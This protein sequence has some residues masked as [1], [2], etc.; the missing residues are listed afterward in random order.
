MIF[1]AGMILGAF[2]GGFSAR[3]R[4]GS[5]FDIAQYA[6]VGGL[7]GLVLGLALTVAVDRIL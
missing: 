1:I 7:I 2:T 5:G 3:R 6:I 4:G